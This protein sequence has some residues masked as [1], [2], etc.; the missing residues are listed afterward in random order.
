MNTDMNTDTNISKKK[1]SHIPSIV[2]IK[3]QE[4]EIEM[5]L[6]QYKLAN[7]A[8]INDLNLGFSDN[9][10]VYLNIMSDLN[11]TANSLLLTVRDEIFTIY[12]KGILNQSSVTLNVPKLK[13]LEAQVR[14]NEKRLKIMIEEELALT[15]KYNASNVE[16]INN[17]YRYIFYIIVAII[18]SWFL[19]RVFSTNDPDDKIESLILITALIIIFYQFIFK[20]L[21]KLLKSIGHFIESQINL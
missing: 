15:G 2:T 14:I 13:E 18:I 1:K 3:A 8:F 5:I 4:K 10:S 11:D 9:A 7:D 19:Y 17:R 12:P 16:I 20:G 6:A 21:I